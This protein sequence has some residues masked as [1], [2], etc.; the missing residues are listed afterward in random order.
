MM[1]EMTDDGGAVEKFD[2]MIS[3]L[4]RSRTIER[5]HC[6]IFIVNEPQ[7]GKTL[8]EFEPMELGLL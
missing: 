2:F 4:S 7:H 6:F 1:T 8:A 5:A 3:R